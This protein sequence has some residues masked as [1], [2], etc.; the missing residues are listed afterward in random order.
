MK[1][2]LALSFATAGIAANAHAAD[3]D[4]ILHHGKIVTVDNRF[5]IHQAIAIRGG[6]IVATGDDGAVLKLKG[7]QTQLVDLR[8]RTVLPGLIDCFAVRYMRNRRRP[9][10][11]IEIV[12]AHTSGPVASEV[13]V[14][15]LAQ[16]AAR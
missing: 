1:R 7:A 8:G 10:T 11:S 12:A 9:T 2:L 13:V 14:T 6:R 4:L 5:S 16:E 3:A 15:R